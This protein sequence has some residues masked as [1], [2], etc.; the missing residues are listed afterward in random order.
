MQFDTGKEAMSF[1]PGPEKSALPLYSI[2]VHEIVEYSREAVVSSLNSM[3][4]LSVTNGAITSSYWDWK[5]LFQ[6][7]GN[8]LTIDFTCMGDNDG[9]WGGSNLTGVCTV[10]EILRIRNY[11]IDSGITAIYVHGADCRM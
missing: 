1:V 8:L 6:F 11:L 9:L 3:A 2:D 4:E 10:T 7:D 5:W